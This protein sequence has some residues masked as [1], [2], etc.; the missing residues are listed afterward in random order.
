LA[1]AAAGACARLAITAGE[2]SDCEVGR[3]AVKFDCATAGLRLMPCA[4]RPAAVPELITAFGVLAGADA[5]RS[6]DIALGARTL[7]DEDKFAALGIG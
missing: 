2:R 5:A 4:V 6:A 3:A 1:F 7:E